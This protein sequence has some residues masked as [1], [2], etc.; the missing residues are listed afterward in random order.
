MHGQQTLKTHTHTHTKQTTHYA[1][2]YTF[3][4]VAGQDRL[5]SYSPM[6]ML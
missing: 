6:R 5:L 3:R 2:V 4:S 1:F